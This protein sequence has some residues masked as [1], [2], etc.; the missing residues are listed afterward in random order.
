MVH[1]DPLTD[2]EHRTTRGTERTARRRT[3]QGG[4]A[5]ECRRRRR[6]R[7][8]VRPVPHRTRIPARVAR[9]EHHR[10]GRSGER[11]AAGDGG[12]AP[13][14][15]QRRLHRC[16]G[17]LRWTHLHRRLQPTGAPCGWITS[18]TPP[19]K[20]RACSVADPRDGPG[21]PRR[22]DRSL[23]GVHGISSGGGDSQLP[24]R[25]PVRRRPQTWARSTSTAVDRRP[26]TRWTPTSSNCSPA[27]C[28]GR[29]ASS[30]GSSPRATPRTP[31]QTRAGDRAPIEQAKGMLMALHRSTRTRPSN[32]RQA[33]AGRP[34]HACVTSPESRRTTQRARGLRR[35]RDR[36]V[37]RAGAADA[38]IAALAEV[39]DPTTPD[40]SP[41]LQDGAG[42]VRRGRRPL[43]RCPGARDPCLWPSGSR[44][45]VGRRCRRR[46]STAR[47]RT[48]ARRLADPR[49][50]VRRGQP[51]RGVATTAPVSASP[52]TTSRP[53]CG[54]G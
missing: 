45:V 51:A 52:T 15:R 39:A 20:G 28:P 35:R 4:H 40:S 47:P 6:C 44:L 2:G 24:R 49:R 26:S 36:L 17:R 42:R 27:P 9:R 33:V 46:C 50:T 18:S 13:G 11:P 10:R 32:L 5:A 12:G 16:D 31:L 43:H 7:G 30:R 41:G 53:S 48:P 54:G 19:A 22:G 29:S 25:S 8:T 23:A 34:T 37:T 38:V 1:I 3:E 21:G 14:D